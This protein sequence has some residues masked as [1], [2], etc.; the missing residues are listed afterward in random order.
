[1]DDL[2]KRMLKMEDIL[3]RTMEIDK[4]AAAEVGADREQIVEGRCTSCERLYP[5]TYLQQGNCIPCW[6]KKN[7]FP[8]IDTEID[9]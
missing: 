4:R 3:E 2:T 7:D 6:R 5:P 8:K 1:M 9:F